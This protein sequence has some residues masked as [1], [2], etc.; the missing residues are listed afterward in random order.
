MS[1]SSK[2]KIMKK[3]KN[4][5]SEEIKEIAKQLL[6]KNTKTEYIGPSPE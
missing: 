4:S 5:A 2:K 1:I 6:L 3:N